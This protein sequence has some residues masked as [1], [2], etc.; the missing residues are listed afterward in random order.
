MLAA[1]VGGALLGCICRQV[2]QECPQCWRT[3]G[4]H[5]VESQDTPMQVS[6][7]MMW[8]WLFFFF[9]GG[10]GGGKEVVEAHVPVPGGVGGGKW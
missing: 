2:S 1:C 9:F 8:N 3:A 4:P 10:G 7:L 5:A 6:Q